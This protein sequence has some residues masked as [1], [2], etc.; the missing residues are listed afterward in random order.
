MIILPPIFSLFYR[1]YFIFSFSITYIIFCI[2][3][4]AKEMRLSDVLAF[5]EGAAAG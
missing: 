2:T 4:S 1:E 3:I 5:T